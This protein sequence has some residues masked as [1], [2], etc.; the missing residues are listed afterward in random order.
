MENGVSNNNNTNPISETTN[1]TDGGLLNLKWIF[2]TLLA[3]WPWF[4]ASLGIAY[5]IAFLYLRYTTPVFQM[6]NEILV[7][8]SRSSMTVSGEA[9][10]LTEMGFNRNSGDNINNVMRSFKK[11]EL[12]KQV[13]AKLRLNVRYY[14]YGRFKTTEFYN[15]SPFVLSIQDSTL[16]G[17]ERG[18]S[19]IFVFNDDGSFKYK[20]KGTETYT[21]GKPDVDLNLPFGEAIIR[22]T[23]YPLHTGNEYEVVITSQMSAARSF[24]GSIGTNRPDKTD[25]SVNITTTDVLPQRGVDIINTLVDV[26]MVANVHEKN[27]N[28]EN[29]IN[30]INERINAV[31]SEL[32]RVETDIETFKKEYDF[33]APEMQSQLLYS[34]TDRYYQE[35]SDLELKMELIK[36]LEDNVAK[37]SKNYQL[38]PTTLFMDNEL[39]TN[40]LYEYNKLL[41]ERELKL[42]SHQEGG[43]QIQA[44]DKNLEGQKKLI[45]NNIAVIKQGLQVKIKEL[46]EKTGLIDQ[47]IKMV[48][49][50]ERLFLEK[51]RKQSVQQALY[52]LLLTKREET[53]VTKA[54]TT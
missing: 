19:Y 23:G 39:L 16:S 47:Q 45:D 46:K 34:N 48:P 12:M 43:F 24:V 40:A 17:L 31:D 44:I 53:A 41:S 2:T 21:A 8:D 14:E 38:V 36:V 42:I 22:L 32:G 54:A 26:Y 4:I 9:K 11:N 18:Y 1:E 28:A 25:N 7:E 5:L 30:F 27:Q 35:L 13:V 10:I 3:T 15:N 6:G 37:A 29:I 51:S 52:I 20:T 33:T 50:K 49:K